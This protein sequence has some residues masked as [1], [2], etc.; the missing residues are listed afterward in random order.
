MKK[1]FDPLRMEKSLY[2]FWEKNGYFKPQNN[3]GKPNFCIVMPPPNITGNLHIGHAFQQTIMDILIRYNRMIGKNTFWQVGTDH[4]GIAT[5]IVVEKKILK[6]EN[7][8]VQQLGKK[9]FLERIWKWKNTSKNVITSQMR[10]LGISVDWTHEKFTLDPQISFAVRKVFM[11]LYDECLIY[12]RKKLVNWDPVL[13]TVISDLEVK[14]RNVIGNMWYIKYYL[15]KNHSIK[16]S[17]EYYLVIATTRPETLFGDTAIAV[18]P[19]DS[20]YKKYIGCYAL[21]PIINRIIP[22]ISDEF[23]DVNKGTGCVKITPA[24]DFNDYEIAMRHN[25]SIINVFT[26]NGKITDV[27]E[28]YDISGEKSCIYKQNVP[29]R[30]HHL[31]RFIARKIIVKELIA[32]KLLIKI[33]KH[34]LAIPYG[35]RSGSVIEP[36]LTDQWYLRVE[37]LAKI[38]VEAVKSGKII[39]IPKKYEK[40]YYSW[41]NN[42]K[43]WCISRQLLWGHRMPI[44]YDKKNN[45]YVGLDEK[46]IRE[47]YHISDDIFLIQETDVLDTWFSSSLWMFSS[48]GWPN[49]KDLFKNFYSTDVV[50]SGFDI[51]FFW[52]ARMIMLSMHLIKD[53][54][55]NGRVPFK[56]VYITGL[57]CDEHGKKMSKSKGNVVD[58]L[59]MIDGISLDALIQKRIKSTVFS[60]HSKKIIT[61]IQSLYPNGINSSGVDALRF[62]CAALSTPTRYIK[63]NINRLYGYRNFC[64]K[65]W[66]A[67]RF[68]LMNL[69]HE[70]EP[71]KLILIKPMSLSD[72]WIVAEF[73]NLVKRYRTALDN[74]RFDIAAN[75]LYEF[76][77]NKFC[78]FYIELVKSFIN[79][80]SML[81]LKSTR[82]TLVYIL[83]SV[84]RLAHPI[85]PFITEEIWQKLQV[86]VKKND[87]NTIMLQSFPKYDVKLV[88]KTILEDMDWIK[89]IFI[90]I[91]S[92]RMDLKIS[93][94]TLIS[95]SF[96]N[97]SSKIHKLIE[98][99]KDYIKK[100][101]YLDNVSI[102]LSNV[103]SMLFF[104]SYIVLGAELLIPYSKIFPKEKE[105]KNLNKEISKIQ[106][107]I[108]KLQQRLSN[109]EFIGKAPIH[110]V[111]KYKNQLQIYIEHKTQ[112]CHKKL[113]MLRD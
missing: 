45:I 77:W 31:D 104:K 3:K 89:N 40:I 86:F 100:I 90:I 19:N 24:H 109:E 25:L 27:I 32:L 8:T 4:A 60:T 98:E 101:A 110:V 6:E 99:H 36:L 57:I 55:G 63:W 61:Q 73:H 2:E 108:N 41:M 42:I 75:V 96:K 28:E 85:I 88:N 93:H 64:N 1:Y 39:F 97:V 30:F 17:Q 74:Y 52:I 9:E 68:I 56:K 50:V 67:S 95:I 43:D 103:D 76:V 84:L 106:L 62:T 46:H 51:I 10:R 79:S 29:L 13:K 81:E 16:I 107:A 71:V 91:R 49:N 7:K 70:V 83:D 65:L 23:V 22:I 38:A 72:R 48:L 113:T 5:Q 94:T 105:L 111:K 82:C 44:W 33:Q 66:N 54:N 78:D 21:V 26:R 47:K 80:C 59:D 20:R 14:N 69:T 18:H 58:P 15:V 112:L 35:E 87:K 11:T 102:I 92:F 53:H 34:N 12:K 37:P